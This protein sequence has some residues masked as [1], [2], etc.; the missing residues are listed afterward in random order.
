MVN[1]ASIGSFGRIR[2]SF[3]FDKSEDFQNMKKIIYDYKKEI[4]DKVSTVENLETQFLYE[5]FTDSDDYISTDCLDLL[6]KRLTYNDGQIDMVVGNSYD[7]QHKKYWQNQD[8]KPFL[9]T[10][11]GR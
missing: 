7:F 8:G 9:L 4:G 2:F 1:I 5:G 10:D 6:S 11:H 3:I